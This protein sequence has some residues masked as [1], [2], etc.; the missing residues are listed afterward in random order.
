[1]NTTQ[2]EH[3]AWAEQGKIHALAGE[4]VL[5]LQYYRV[6]MQAAV[7]QGEP[8]VVFRHYLE[9]SLESLEKSSAFKDVLAYCDKALEHYHSHPP[10]HLLSE[11]DLAA[12]HQRRGLILTKLQQYDLAECAFEDALAAA[13][14]GQVSLPL[15]STILRWLQSGLTIRPE[16]VQQEQTRC[17]YWSVRPDTVRKSLARPLPAS[18]L[19]QSSPFAH[20]NSSHR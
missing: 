4:H 10:Q 8:E 13:Q 19:H 2:R 18:V 20:A 15:S 16:R 14:R 1:M 7:Q 12:I 11:R 6:A 5:A 9:C 3:P 17:C